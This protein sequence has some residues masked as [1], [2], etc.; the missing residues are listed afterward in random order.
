MIRTTVEIDSRISKI[1]TEMVPKVEAA[2]MHGAKKVAQAAKERVP[3]ET[4]KLRDSI[5]AI[6]PGAPLEVAVVAGATRRWDR[7]GSSFDFPYGVVVEYG[8]KYHP[9]H[10]FLVPALES[11]RE[12]ILADVRA[13]LET[14]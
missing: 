14:L 13:G 2:M 6:N 11:R 5:E 7:P 12:E 10:P 9:P 3:V 1:I 4:G 8:G